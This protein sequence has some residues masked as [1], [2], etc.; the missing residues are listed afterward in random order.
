MHFEHPILL[1]LLP[2][3]LLPL[4]MRR[5]K[6]R[7]PSA[8]HLVR[9]S[10]RT[11]VLPLLPLLHVLAIAA[12]VLAA[13]AP[14]TG[15]RTIHDARSARDVV[16]A[17]DTS[18]S[19]E[20]RDFE[21]PGGVRSRWEGAVAL[22]SDFVRRREGDR[23]GVVAF[24]GRAVTQCPLT[25]DG[26]LAL[27]LLEQAE[28]NMLGKRTALGEA[29]VLGVARLADGGGAL[30]VISDGQNTAGEV[31][32]L[33]AA[34]LAQSR[35]VRI[36]AIGIGSGGAVQVPVRLPSGRTVLRE[37][38]YPLDEATLRQMAA[39]SGGAFFR[40]SDAGALKQVFA[41]IDALE[42]S[43]RRE[44]RRVAVGRA[45]H[46]IALWG[47]GLLAVLMLASSV[48]LRSAPLLR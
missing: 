9:S 3:A 38:T 1:L 13:A 39:V 15:T 35:G 22:A 2:L 43:P 34:H 42:A 17:L 44:A 36:Y 24:G 20:G 45:G 33:E 18:E 40:A 46:R 32:P 37:K 8:E 47:A 25:F 48:P 5:A 10:V 19:M 29:V 6:V 30:V 4:L 21:T 12:A 27:W 14:H 16:L 26:A 31:G 23:T 28:P 41:E 11:R 7:L